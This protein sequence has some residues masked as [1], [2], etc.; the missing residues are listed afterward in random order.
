MEYQNPVMEGQI[1]RKVQTELER[2]WQEGVLI[3]SK[4]WMWIKVEKL[5][6]ILRTT[7]KNARYFV[8]CVPDSLKQSFDGQEYVRGY[9]VLEHLAKNIEENEKKKKGANLEASKQ[10]YEAI[11]TCPTVKLRRIE[12]DYTLNAARKGL[13]K[14]RRTKYKIKSDELTGKPL[15]VRTCEF[16]HIR[17]YALYKELADQI[18]NGLIVNKE[19][20]RLI[21]ERGINDEHE[22]L[23]LCQEQQWATDWYD[24]FRHK[25]DF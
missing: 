7:K 22:L 25:F 2:A 18:D 12:Y 10:Y 20:H 24:T 17:S 3:D 16:S 6:S 13:K 14:K 9:K 11:N 8:A 19:T 21:T 4:G 1:S 23:A 15:V 5:H